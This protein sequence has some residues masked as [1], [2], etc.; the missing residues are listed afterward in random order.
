MNNSNYFLKD[1]FTLLELVI[2][3]IIVAVLAGL[4]LPLFQGAIIKARLTESYNVV[5]AIAKAEEIYYAQY[6]AYICAEA[7]CNPID[8]AIGVWIA[9]AADK[10]ALEDDLGVKLPEGDHFS[11]GVMQ[12]SLGLE[13]YVRSN[14]ANNGAT[15]YVARVDPHTGHNLWLDMGHPWGKYVSL[16]KVK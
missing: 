7:P 6:G 12:G 2:V 4:G 13:I 3:V 1:G 10:Q 14:I 16:Y 8:P 9:G 11:Y 15:L 5:S